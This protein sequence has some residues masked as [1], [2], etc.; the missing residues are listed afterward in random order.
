MSEGTGS[1]VPHIEHLPAVYTSFRERFPDVAAALDTLGQ[2]S[3]TAGPLDEREQRLVTL[4]IAI[5]GLAR[6]A[7]RSNARKALGLGVTPGEIRHVAV[8]AVTTRGFPTAIAGYEW[9]EEVLGE[10]A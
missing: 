2:A 10:E 4:G 1:D 8:L 9:I 3:E 5:G 6:G 7:V